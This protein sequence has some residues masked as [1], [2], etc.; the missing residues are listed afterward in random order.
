[1]AE[2]LSEAQKIIGSFTLTD[3]EKTSEDLY[4]FGGGDGKNDYINSEENKKYTIYI[5]KDSKNGCT[6]IDIDRYY[7]MYNVISPRVEIEFRTGANTWININTQMVNGKPAFAATV[8]KDKTEIVKTVFK[9]EKDGKFYEEGGETSLE[10]DKDYKGL[11]KVISITPIIP[12]KNNNFFVSATIEDTGYR[13]LQLELYDRT[14]TTVQT[15][16]YKAIQSTSIPDTTETKQTSS[17]QTFNLDFI[18]ETTYVS[19]NIRIRYGYNDN[20]D[21]EVKS[22]YY[23][24]MGLGSSSYYKGKE[25][26]YRWVSRRNNV[27]ATIS[28]S[29]SGAKEEDLQEN[30]TD[31]VLMNF[32]NQTTI[33]GGFEEF[34]ITG[35]QTTLT[36]SGMKYTINAVGNDAMKLN[37]YKF[38]QKYANIV[39]KPDNILASLMHAFNYK[40]AN[41]PTSTK[42][43]LVKLIY[44]D[45]FKLIP[46]KK[47]IKSATGEYMALNKDDQTKKLDEIKK[48]I[49]EYNEK[50]I[51]GEKLL[52][53]FTN[54]E[55]HDNGYIAGNTTEQQ[56]I[57]SKW[58][59]DSDIW[60]N[61]SKI[62]EYV[63]I[64]NQELQAMLIAQ[65][66][67]NISREQEIVLN[68]WI[69]N[70]AKSRLY[71]D[72]IKENSFPLSK[73]GRAVSTLIVAN[74]AYDLENTKIISTI[75]EKFKT[76]AAQYERVDALVKIFKVLQEY[77]QGNISKYSNYKLG[78]AEAGTPIDTAIEELL[79]QRQINLTD[80]VYRS[81]FV[82]DNFLKLPLSLFK[83]LEDEEA[84]KLAY[85]FFH[86]KDGGIN[87]YDDGENYLQYQLSPT[88][89][90][91]VKEIVKDDGTSFKKFR[92]EIE[93]ITNVKNSKERCK[94]FYNILTNISNYQEADI[95]A[96]IE[97]IEK[98][99]TA[100]NAGG[101]D[102]GNKDA[103]DLIIALCYALGISNYKNNENNSIIING[104]EGYTYASTTLT[105]GEFVFLENLPGET[106]YDV[107]S[108]G[109]KDENESDGIGVEKFKIKNTLIK[110]LDDKT[111]KIDC[112]NFMRKLDN[113]CKEFKKAYK[114]EYEA[115]NSSDNFSDETVPLEQLRKVV[116]LISNDSV[117]QIKST[118]SEFSPSERLK[119][120]R[121]G[122]M[123][124]NDFNEIARD[125]TSKLQD[126]NIKKQEKQKSLSELSANTINDEISLSLGGPDALNNDKKFYKSIS[127][128]LT[129]FC[130]ACPPM[131]DYDKEMERLKAY[132]E[133]TNPNGSTE[134]IKTYQDEYGNKQTLDL[135]GN[136]PT[137]K[138]TWDIIGEYGEDEQHKIPVVGIYYRRP[139]IPSKLRRY[140]WGSGNPEMHAIKS[141]SISTESEFAMLS[142]AANT[143][144]TVNGGRKVAIK[145]TD[146]KTLVNGS[147]SDDAIKSA[148][149]DYQL[150][151]DGSPSFF[152]TIAEGD[153]QYKITDAMF[154][155]INKGTITV[156]GDPSLRF[157][158]GVSPMTFPIYLDISLQNEGVTWT[159]NNQGQKSTLSG[160][161][162]VSKITHNLN[163]QGYTT[164]MEIIRYPGINETVM[165]TNS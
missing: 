120:L 121:K 97:N 133:R 57:Y 55:D 7:N 62:N 46:E 147:A 61:E 11:G 37:G 76:K 164:T 152:K 78:Q 40:D 100:I 122:R 20:V 27:P 15:L 140:C 162:V 146:N 94:Y 21:T 149:N 19:N 109:G 12:T 58:K 159:N 141:L 126:L 54:R 82:I 129:E 93:E 79:E 69:K 136:M 101:S 111:S 67:E 102:G 41:K 4:K 161:Y 23:K 51:F 156:L 103:K 165:K 17:S 6:L 128:L 48:E 59:F 144:L 158:G 116:G 155:A 52:G 160:V 39:D 81:Y 35:V 132:D 13:A 31:N 1:M 71:L 8:K 43:T 44:C 3:S 28:K 86:N 77:F 113:A 49:A 64:N 75:N 87:L 29:S 89:N 84:R 112:D 118:A 33:L 25:N 60:C 139:R 9:N 135:S 131:H 104:K 66:I 47:I 85:Q 88:V 105:S 14:F 26:L 18:K 96:R 53:C 107:Y 110:E 95:R 70:Y 38:V 99:K 163:I 119:L 154:Q 151:S 117:G 5:P 24:Q 34:Y 148:Y 98:L 73:I 114:Q 125:I 10:L 56:T 134:E 2:K 50:I 32:N 36:N 143:T 91:V 22:D 123:S 16:I 142:S 137:Y 145:G 108:L 153:D 90:D 115:K 30:S 45:N 74:N 72:S 124:I 42:E 68:Y 65:G 80:T 106:G 157:G 83:A 138:L 127:S 150:S 63:N 130:N 92:P